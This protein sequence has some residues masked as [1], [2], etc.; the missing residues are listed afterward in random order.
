MIG[1]SILSTNYFKTEESPTLTVESA[2]KMIKGIIEVHPQETTTAS[3]DTT[4]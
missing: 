2:S 1:T 4:P 3:S